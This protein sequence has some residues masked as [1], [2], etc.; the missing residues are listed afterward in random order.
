MTTTGMWQ[1]AYVVYKDASTISRLKADVWSLDIMDFSVRVHPLNLSKEDYE[2][3]EAYSLKLT[4]LLFGTT[5]H[6]L[7][8]IIEDTNAKSCYIPRH[9]QSYKNLPIAI[10]S[11]DCDDRAHVAYEKNFSLKGRKLYWNFPGIPNCRTCG[12][13]DHVTKKC[14]SKQQRRSNPYS[15]LYDKYKPAQYRPRFPSGSRSSQSQ[16]NS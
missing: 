6:D 12:N 10:F 14:P 3:C 5:Q 13:P 4:G 9:T 7:R 16:S 11:F 2:D 8:Q 1:R 15:Q